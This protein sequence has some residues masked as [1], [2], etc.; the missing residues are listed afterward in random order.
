[1]N[2]EIGGQCHR[3]MDSMVMMVMILMSGINDN[4]GVTWRL[5]RDD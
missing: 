4:A 1:V 5:C 2:G 3:V